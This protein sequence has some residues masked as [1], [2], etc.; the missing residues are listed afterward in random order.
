MKKIME[1]I[2]VV[3]ISCF[4]I[5][6]P[7][8]VLAQ[9]KEDAKIKEPTTKLES[10]LAKKGKLIVKDFYK[11]GEISSKYGSK[12]DFNALVI[13]EPGQET[14]KIRGLKVEVTEG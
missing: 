10:F 12:V 1:K 13:Y 8:R 11:L 14:Q 9:V 4:V 2:M 5:I 3:A 7:S 6:V